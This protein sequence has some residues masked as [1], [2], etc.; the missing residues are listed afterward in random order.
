MH[1]YIKSYNMSRRD[2]RRI[3]EL[4][5]PHHTTQAIYECWYYIIY[6]HRY[7][8]A[9]KCHCYVLLLFFF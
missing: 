7:S 8:N 9:L 2:Y 5:T 6:I 3:I 1:T 4:D